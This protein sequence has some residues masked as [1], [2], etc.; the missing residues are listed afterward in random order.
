MERGDSNQESQREESQRVERKV[1]ECYQWKA[2]G[3]CSK[4]DSCNSRHEVASGNRCGEGRKE[5]SSS[6]AP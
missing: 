2:I 6:L 1:E 3:Q 4:G 5:Q